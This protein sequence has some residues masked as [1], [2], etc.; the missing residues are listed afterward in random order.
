[1]VLELT[2]VISG[3]FSVVLIIFYIII[4]IIICS[5]YFKVKQKVFLYM[6]LAWF[7]LSMI[8]WSSAINIF[9]Y[10]IDP[11]SNGFP[12]AGF[13]IL[14][15]TPIFLAVILF[16]VPITD[17]TFKKY[18]RYLLPT[19]IIVEVTLMIVGYILLFINPGLINTKPENSVTGV[20]G[21]YTLFY[22]IIALILIEFL[23]IAFALDSFRSDDRLLKIK[24]ILIFIAYILFLIG[25]FLDA[26]KTNLFLDFIDRIIL[27]ASVLM[28]YFGFIMPNWLKSRILEKE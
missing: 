25:A 16:A 26:R 6:G 27:I 1:M 14:S 11:N 12:G 8:W 10:I 4:G 7:A 18:R 20:N 21:T 24:G 17:L 15:G 13:F 28:F 3:I 23:G 9:L 5:K 22:I 19:I 2:D